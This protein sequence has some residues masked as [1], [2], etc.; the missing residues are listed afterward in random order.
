MLQILSGDVQI[1]GP[2]L[3]PKSGPAG[4]LHGLNAICWTHAGLR[5]NSL[6]LRGYTAGLGA[7]L[8]MNAGLCFKTL[9]FQYVDAGTR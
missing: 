8:N 9:G 3:D 4:L 7:G 5:M 6:M 2:A 1:H